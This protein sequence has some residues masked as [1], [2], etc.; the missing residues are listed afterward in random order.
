MLL[1][2]V[3]TASV[4]TVAEEYAWA[5]DAVD[6]CSA[7]GILEG[8][9]NGDFMLGDLVTQ[10]QTAA[11]LSRTFKTD[12]SKKLSVSIVNKNHWAA[13]HVKKIS[14][15]I[16][17]PGAFNPDAPASREM[18]ISTLCNIIGMKGR[19]ISVLEEDFD[20]CKK[21]NPDYAPY[22]AAAYAEGLLKGSD[23]HINPTGNL[24]RAEAVT[25]IYRALVSTEEAEEIPFSQPEEEVPVQKTTP[26]LGEAQVTLERAI[27]WAESKNAAQIF[28]DAAPFYW[29]YGELTGIRPEALYAQAALETGYGTY[30]GKVLPEMNNW[31]GIKKYGATGDETEDHE[32]FETPED[33]VRAHFNHMSAYVGVDPVGEPHGRYKSVKSLTWAG[34]VKYIEELGG[35]WCPF[36]DYGD[37]IT[38][39]IDEM[40]N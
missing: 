7:K 8:N 16:L 14:G 23:G 27:Q 9:E 34:T 38:A 5:K 19:K 2:S 13:E 25:F 39:L 31:A 35:K 24:T 29:K 6:Y 37:R 10:A 26:L 28:T 30:K 21:I 20:D 12:D 33:G 15:Y 4:Q 22:L 3:F 17:L 32:S 11:L 36:A 18:F 40:Q 1:V